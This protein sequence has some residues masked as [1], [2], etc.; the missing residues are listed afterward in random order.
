[1]EAL[2][3]IADLILNATDTRVAE[4]FDWLLIDDNPW[5]LRTLLRIATETELEQ[6]DRLTLLV[7]NDFGYWAL[8]TQDAEIP[9]QDSLHMVE[10]GRQASDLQ[11]SLGWEYDLRLLD[12]CSLAVWAW[13]GNYSASGGRVFPLRNYPSLPVDG[14]LWNTVD[15]QKTLPE[16]RQV[17]LDQGWVQGGP[18]ETIAA[19]EYYFYFDRGPQGGNSS[20]W[21]YASDANG[22][23]LI[24]VE[25]M[26]VANHDLNNADF[27]WHHYVDTGRGI[28]ECG[29]NTILV[30]AIAKSLGIPVT[31]VIR[32]ATDSSQV[33]DS[34]MFPLFRG[35]NRWTAYRQE[36]NV[37]ASPSLSYTVYVARPPINRFGYLS[38]WLEEP[39]RV[40]WFGSMY[41]IPP[42][43]LGIEEIRSTFG[44]GVPVET[45]HQWLCQ[46]QIEH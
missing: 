20:H 46:D 42:D 7:A 9:L 41:Y 21:E 17:A 4:A 15:A 39:Y 11:R 45:M 10:Q 1:V 35:S 37:P 6:N 26:Q 31:A 2:A 18:A 16:M 32:Q 23:E 8:I 24:S 28:G 44:E 22:H 34:H 19:I 14:Y 33:L 13:T 30:D 29:D 36:L 38:Y 12:N 40:R 43:R 27:I 25:D 3:D 5:K